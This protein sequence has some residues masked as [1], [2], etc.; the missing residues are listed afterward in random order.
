LTL[1]GSDGRLA[2]GKL[3]KG[4]AMGRLALLCLAFGCCVAGFAG[5]AVAATKTSVTFTDTVVSVGAP[6]RVW[7]S[8]DQVLHVRGQPQTTVVAGDLTGTFQ[9]VA[10]VNLDLNTGTGELF[11][12]FTLTTSSVTWVG[13]FTAQITSAGVSGT[14]VGQGDDGTKIRGSFTSISANSFLNQAVILDPHG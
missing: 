13:S 4:E 10:N 8:D 11:G 7:V 3:R 6:E 14:F 2:A 1:L 9:L 12:K 5:S